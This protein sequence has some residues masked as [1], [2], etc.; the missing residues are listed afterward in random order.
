MTIVVAA[1]YGSKAIIAADT[2]IVSGE[3]KVKN[4]KNFS[5]IIKFPHFVVGFAGDCSIFPVL[6]EYANNGSYLRRK[7]M[8]MKTLNDAT[9]FYKDIYEGLKANIECSPSFDK[10]KDGE[11]LAEIIIL[12]KTSIF[13]ANSYMFVSEYT[14]YTTTGAGEDLAT[15][16]LAH[17][18]K[19]LKS[20]EELK[21]LVEEAVIIA[22]EHN[23][24]CALPMQLVELGD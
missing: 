1:I 7:H 10:E 18:Y 11:E 2:L 21:T 19:R 22:C 24:Y 16:V 23:S 8:K 9:K 5:K 15:G 6:H 12:T 13:K 17:A 3:Q 4:L 20:E 14:N